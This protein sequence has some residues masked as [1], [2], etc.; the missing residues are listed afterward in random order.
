MKQFLSFQKQH[1]IFFQIEPINLKSLNDWREELKT[2]LKIQQ[3][4]IS[5][6][7]NLLKKLNYTKLNR[8][9]SQKKDAQKNA[10]LLALEAT[11]K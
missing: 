1:C 11:K 7:K 6:V 8:L 5:Y 3:I 10:A 4:D 2:K 9:E